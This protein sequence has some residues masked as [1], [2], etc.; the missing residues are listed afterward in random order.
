MKD[1]ID[2]L[3]LQIYSRIQA[4]CN[5]ALDP[6]ALSILRAVSVEY[7]QILLSKR[8]PKT[9]AQIINAIVDRF[10]PMFCTFN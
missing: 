3:F 9:D 6:C 7:I 8:Q 4:R 5:Y 1:R 10:S 2:K